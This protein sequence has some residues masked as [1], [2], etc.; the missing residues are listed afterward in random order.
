MSNQP[1]S[2]QGTSTAFENAALDRFR[3]LI[4]ILP[5][6]CEIYREVWNQSTVLTFDFQACPELLPVVKEQSFLL[7]LGADHL[8]L[9][10][11]ISFRLGKK[12][13]GWVNL[14]STDL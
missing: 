9:S 4:V 7:L 3:E 8:G 5:Q 12:I 2:T 10:Q 14:T 1:F 6:Q 11:S 13:E